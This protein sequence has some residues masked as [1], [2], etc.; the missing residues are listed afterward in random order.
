MPEALLLYGREYTVEALVEAVAADKDFYVQSGG[1]VTCS[2]GEPLMQPAFLAEF[3]SACKNAGF[4]TAVDT[5][6]YAAWQ[7]FVEILPH[8]DLFLYDIKHMNAAEHKRLTGVDNRLIMENLRKIAQAGV[9]VEVRM[10]VLPGYNDHDENIRQM[11]EMLKGISSL[12]L[13]R[14]LAYHG[15]A[16]SKYAAINLAHDLPAADG[17]ETA[18]AAR[19]GE[20]LA[21]EGICVG[22]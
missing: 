3:L 7:S 19:V 12:T 1:G 10:P 2:G 17:Q 14:P 8:T 20:M 22:G 18:A 16:G 9:P 11:A 21:L 6:G 5:S 4:S 15:L 13:V